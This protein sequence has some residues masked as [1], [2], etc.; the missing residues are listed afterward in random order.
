MNSRGNT[1]SVSNLTAPLRCGARHVDIVRTLMRA[2]RI[3][4]YAI[5]LV[6]SLLDPGGLHDAIRR[7]IPRF[8]HLMAS[9]CAPPLAGRRNNDPVVGGR[10][11]AAGGIGWTSAIAP[12]FSQPGAWDL[13]GSAC[14]WAS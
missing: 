7:G 4:D 8:D 9:G 3:A 14:T 1:W 13:S 10:Y 12:L 11:S 6:A 5:D 2:P